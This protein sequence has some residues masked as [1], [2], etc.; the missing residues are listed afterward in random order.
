MKQFECTF[1]SN[2]EDKVFF[3]L[4][5]SADKVGIKKELELYFSSIDNLDIKEV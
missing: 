4:W 2:G 5:M 3:I 1:Q